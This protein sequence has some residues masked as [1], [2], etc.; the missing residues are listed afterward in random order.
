MSFKKRQVRFQTPEVSELV[1]LFTELGLPGIKINIDDGESLS[2][3][4]VLK[5]AKFR[6]KNNDCLISR[7]VASLI[8]TLNKKRDDDDNESLWQALLEREIQPQAL[9]MM[10]YQITENEKSNL[11]IL[12]STLYFALLQVPGSF[13]YH[14]FNSMVFLS[15]ITAVKRWI[16]TVGGMFFS[17]HFFV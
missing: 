3:V 4:S 17:L 15:C 14:V 9:I 2:L 1:D 10:I 7:A 6:H 12:A 8:P 11:S 13:I 16:Y 5:E